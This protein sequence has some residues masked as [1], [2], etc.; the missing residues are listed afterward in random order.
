LG[1][2]ISNGY[3]RSISIGYERTM[4]DADDFWNGLRD[5][6]TVSEAEV[7]TRL[8]LPLL[9]ALGYSS[10]EI[11][12]KPSIVFQEGRRGRNPEADFIVHEKPTW[13]KQTSLIVIEAKTPYENM[14]TAKRQGESYAYAT[15]SPF[16]LICDGRELSIWQLQLSSNSI[17]ALTASV[18][19][20]AAHRGQIE[21]LIGRSAA[22][23]YSRGLVQRPASEVADDV[24]AYVRAVTR[25]KGPHEIDRRLTNLQSSEACTASGFFQHLQREAFVEAPSGYGKTVLAEALF[26]SAVGNLAQEKPLPFLLPITHLV[27]L[28]Q[29]PMNYCQDRVKA[30]CPQF[31]SSH[32]FIELMRTRGILLI[33]DGFD[34]V[35]TAAQ[36]KLLTD[37][38]TLSCDYPRI[39]Y[40]LLGRAGPAGQTP[41]QRFR[42]DG[43]NAQE[44]VELIKFRPSAK[45]FAPEIP[46]GILGKLSENPLLLTLILDTK[47]KTGTWPRELGALFETWLSRLLSPEGK[48]PSLLYRLRAMLVSVA[49]AVRDL[50]RAPAE[51]LQAVASADPQHDLIDRLVELGAVQIH[52][53]VEIEH[54]AL[55]E[56]LQ[57][58]ELLK[59]PKPHVLEFIAE[60]PF[61]SGGFVAPLIVAGSRDPEVRNAMWV[62]AAQGSA[63]LYFDLLRY[64]Y[65]PELAGDGE[66]ASRSHASEVLRGFTEP[67]LEFFPKLAPSLMQAA[68]MQKAEHLGI[69]GAFERDGQWF[70]YAFFPAGLDNDVR[71]G[72]EIGTARSGH[73]VFAKYGTNNPRAIGLSELQRALA[74]LIDKRKLFGGPLWRND[75]AA[76]RLRIAA[77]QL[78][79]KVGL[80]HDAP[81]CDLEARLF[82]YENYVFT[83]S[84]NHGNVPVRL[85]LEDL[86]ALRLDGRSKLDIWW[87]ISDSDPLDPNSDPVALAAL[88]NE[89]WRR[90]QQI[91]KE[92]VLSNFPR[93]AAELAFYSTMPVRFQVRVAPE[94]DWM[95]RGTDLYPWPVADWTEA[96]ADVRVEAMT[97]F[98][99]REAYSRIT[100][101]ARRLGRSSLSSVNF[102]QGSL[103]R[104]DGSRRNAPADGETSALRAALNFLTADLNRL[105]ESAPKTLSSVKFRRYDD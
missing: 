19:T 18:S 26:Q 101:E 68:C 13:T 52:P 36:T 64:C 98:D 62:R 10:D 105:F 67:M 103:P 27:Q 56:Y 41:S 45:L 65:L 85:L 94:I 28:Q 37:L 70:S 30:Y 2:V 32:A 58:A 51:V 47:D 90:A 80:D 55:A 44:Q 69:E 40:V 42:L 81:I 49:V 38:A 97:S 74:S 24:S 33:L 95:G 14:A 86:A 88:I 12:P 76:G 29:N 35:S 39:S 17:L 102:Y 75:L 83:V 61:S 22:V 104:I 11:T 23:A 20:L 96:G 6:A 87:D 72:H 82:A 84:A 43:L 3:E 78:R 59:R 50:G 73:Q 66:A 16:L 8:I 1:L 5:I 9:E 71:V 21:K 48:L 92:L 93:L 54:D 63:D 7:E 99:Y 46:P 15:G 53:Q 91:Y 100:A 77:Q 25:P 89:H 31:Q 34:R 60:H 57:V 4:L 79:T